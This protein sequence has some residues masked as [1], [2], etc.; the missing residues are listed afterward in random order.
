VDIE[1]GQ[2]PCLVVVA[3]R[4]RGVNFPAVVACGLPVWM[5]SRRAGISL[6]A[7]AKPLTGCFIFRQT[8]PMK[9]AGLMQSARMLYH[10]ELQSQ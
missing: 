7:T 8:M 1:A 6:Q 2:L 5:E 9:H 3:G 10:A 4:N